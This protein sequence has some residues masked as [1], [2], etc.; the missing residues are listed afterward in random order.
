M[1]HRP[2]WVMMA[3][4]SAIAA[5]APPPAWTQTHEG[6][7]PAASVPVLP[8]SHD[9][10]P[11][12]DPPG[13]VRPLEADGPGSA[14][15]GKSMAVEVHGFRPLTTRARPILAWTETDGR[16]V[17]RTESDATT[18]RIALDLRWLNPRHW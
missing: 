6:E 14:S 8:V 15:S 12:T 18:L 11:P 16:G 9:G 13:E 2:G 1:K 5:V 17:H 3:G 7:P 10:M 4:L